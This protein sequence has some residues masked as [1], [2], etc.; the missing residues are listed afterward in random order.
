M[1][2]FQQFDVHDD[3]SAMKVGTDGVLLGA[4]A[5]ASR[6]PCRALDVGTGCGLIALMMAQRFPEAQITAIDIDPSSLRDARSNVTASPFADRITTLESAIQNFHGNG[7]RFDL[8]VCNPPFFHNQLPSPNPA[9]HR[10]R[11]QATL[12]LDELLAGAARCMSADGELSLILPSDQKSIAVQVAAA[13]GLCPMRITRVRP[14]P[15][16]DFVRVLIAL[17]NQPGPSLVQDELTLELSKHHYTPEFRKLTE[18]FYLNR[19]R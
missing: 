19:E 2:H 10:A 4:W 13:H 14:L 8:V 5:A 11:H 3:R 12:T 1:F 17:T 7:K 6:S 18:S 9:R 15:D 16:R